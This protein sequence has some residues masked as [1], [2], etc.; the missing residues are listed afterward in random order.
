MYLGLTYTHAS[1]FQM[2]RGSVVIFTGILSVVVLKRKLYAF[3]WFGMFLVLVGLALVGYVLFLF[4][5]LF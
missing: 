4:C 3:N 1:V 5:F 2:L